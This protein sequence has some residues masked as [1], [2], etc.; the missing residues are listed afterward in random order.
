MTDPVALDSA[1]LNALA[2]AV[3]VR[4]ASRA[5]SPWLTVS[6]A[7]SYL[8]CPESRLRKLVMLRA[9]PHHRDG[10]RVLFHREELDQYVRDGGAFAA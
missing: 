3:A 2:D 8:R 10:R 9:V 5:S 4:V 1:T 6:E 7:A